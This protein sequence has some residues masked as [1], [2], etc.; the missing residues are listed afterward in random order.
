[1][2]A[3]VNLTPEGKSK[4]YGFVDQSDAATIEDWVED[5]ETTVPIRRK[6]FT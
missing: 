1:M 2:P 6:W 3:D 4:R 5:E